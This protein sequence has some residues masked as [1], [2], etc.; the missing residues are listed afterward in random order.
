MKNEVYEM[1]V[2]E[3][4]DSICPNTCRNF[5]ELCTGY[6]RDGKKLCYVDTE[7]DRIVPGSFVQGGNLRKTLGK[8]FEVE[9][10]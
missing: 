5:R 7:F 9:N 10:F 4:F 3:L 6:E 2:I 1:I 8:Y